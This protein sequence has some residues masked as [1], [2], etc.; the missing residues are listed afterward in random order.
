MNIH[1]TVVSRN[2]KI[3][4]FKSIEYDVLLTT[5][6]MNMFDDLLLIADTFLQSMHC[7]SDISLLWKS[8]SE[9]FHV[10][11]LKINFDTNYNKQQFFPFLIKT[12]LP[13]KKQFI[14]TKP[15]TGKIYIMEISIDYNEAN[16]LRTI[17]HEKLICPIDCIFGNGKYYITDKGAVHTV[18]LLM[19][20]SLMLHSCNPKNVIKFPFSIA[21]MTQADSDDG[22][23]VVS[24]LE[25]HVIIDI[26]VETDVKAIVRKYDYP[27]FD[28]GPV[29][30][31]LINSPAGIYCRGSSL[32]LAENPK[33]HA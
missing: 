2:H 27:G 8:P 33:D 3:E 26:A 19:D 11:T 25:S 1:V 17:T 5:Q 13:N 10:C 16:I 6:E 14:V 23:V 24:D 4:T 30:V 29:E 9:T 20:G 15:V 28:D 7:V 31:A 21:V 32:Y 12:C 22:R 18:Q